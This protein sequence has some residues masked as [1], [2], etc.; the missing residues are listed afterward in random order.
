MG[1]GFRG[2]RV[3]KDRGVKKFGW[4]RMLMTASLCMGCSTIGL[5]LRSREQID[6]SRQTDT[7]QNVQV[8]KA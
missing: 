8:F 4:H 3:G 5:Y 7:P 2:I 1:C 6:F